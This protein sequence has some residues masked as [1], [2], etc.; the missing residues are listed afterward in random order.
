MSNTNVIE[1]QKQLCLKYGA[2]YYPAH[3]HL[4]L[5]ISEN[6]KEGF[7]PINGLRITPE[8]EGC[9]SSRRRCTFF[10]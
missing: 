3:E 10:Y 5:G 2:K 9:I 8:E 4:K 1:K 6:V 7:V